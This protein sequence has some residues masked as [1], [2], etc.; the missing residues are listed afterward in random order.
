[1]HYLFWQRAVLREARRQHLRHNFD[2][3]HHLSWGAIS[4]P[5]LVWRLRIPFVWGPVGGGQIA[6]AAF[7]RYF[8]LRWTPELLR[9]LRVKMATF[10]PNLRRTVQES[11][12]ILSTNPETNSGAKSGRGS[13]VCFFPNI[14]VPEQLVGYTPETRPPDRKE[15]NH[16]LGRPDDSA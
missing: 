14:G 16:S 12:L 6:P 4:A 8:G 15:I 1:M 7:R 3:V 9:T 10:T 5:P 11:A 13:R 2:L